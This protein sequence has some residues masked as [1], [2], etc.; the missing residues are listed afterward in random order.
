MVARSS[1]R[2]RIGID[3]RLIGYRRGIGNYVHHLVHGLAALDSTINLVLYGHR[4]T[5][6]E[7]VP[8]SAHITK[9]RLPFAPYPLWEQV[10]LPIAARRDRLDILHCP[11]NTAPLRLSRRV[12]LVV[13]VHD[14]TYLMR[15]THGDAGGI[16]KRLARAYR[17]RVVPRL[18]AGGHQII[19]VSNASRDDMLRLLSG[20]ADSVAV[21]YEAGNADCRPLAPNAV[22]DL[23]ER[24]G[25]RQ[26]YV[27]ALGA[28]D[29]HKNTRR[30]IDAFAAIAAGPAAGHA[31]V[32]AGLTAAGIRLVTAR[33]REH[34]LADRI[35]PLAY[36]DP[37]V[38]VHLYNGAR[39]F[40]VPSLYESFG[41]PVL[42]SMMC[43]VPVVASTAGGLPEVGGTAAEWVDPLSIDSIAAGLARVLTD[44]A[45][46]ARLQHAGFEQ[47]RKFSWD[48]TVRETLD[49]YRS[50]LD[51]S[52]SQAMGTRRSVA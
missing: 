20:F 50:L 15:E 4:K 37:D 24:F 36:V 49:V 31:L 10:H 13:T 46:R 44:T 47:A 41:L 45:L 32:V 39:A 8:D 6:F 3:V 5:A 12:K 35:I 22:I 16:T 9:R 11:A 17:A 21:I 48:R 25:I 43:G 38:L 18:F 14:I 40:S 26:P 2:L 27:L 28:V 51:T 29:V 33:A 52:T 42:E 23:R 7:A 34:G 30:L 1:H 19:T